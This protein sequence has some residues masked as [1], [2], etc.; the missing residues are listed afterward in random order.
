MSLIRFSAV[1]SKFLGLSAAV[2]LLGCA[3]LVA[4][5]MPQVEPKTDLA[6]IPAGRYEM[7]ASHA[8]VTFEINHM[9]FSTY[10][11]RFNKISGSLDFNANTPATSTAEVKIDPASVDTN[12]SVLEE[13]LRGS[14]FFDVKAYPDLTYK[15]DRLEITGPAT[16]K[17]YGQLSMHGVTRP[18][19]MDVTFRGGAKNPMTGDFTL[20]FAANGTLKRSDYGVSSYVPLISDEVTLLF[21]AEFTKK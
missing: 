5:I 12:N 17:L 1:S 20:G 13:S 10:V 21:N 11:G 6:A 9:N 14:K 3:S 4:E 16:G 8:N 2:M 7:D 18:L 15:S 19:V